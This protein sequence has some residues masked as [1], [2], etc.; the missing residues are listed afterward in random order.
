MNPNSVRVNRDEDQHWIQMVALG[1]RHRDEGVRNLFLKYRRRL[2]AFLVRRGADSHSAEDMLQE[3]FVK[4]VHGAESFRNDAKVSTWIF[5]IARNLH[6]DSLRRTN[7]EGTVGEDEWHRIEAEIA[8]TEGFQA[9]ESWRVEQAWVCV[10]R[11][12]EEFAVVHPAAAEVLDKVVRE[13]WST[14]DA[15]QFLQRTEGATREFLSQCR[16]KLRRYL[17]PCLEHFGGS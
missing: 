3:V 6:I 2:L 9:D 13:G 11:A 8:A 7:L 10:E 1:G 5:Q 15:A 12:F 14:R 16:K 4:V 17:E